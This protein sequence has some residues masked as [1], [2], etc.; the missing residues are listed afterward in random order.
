MFENVE[1]EVQY[2]PRGTLRLKG[3]V[4][5]AKMWG[6]ALK[7]AMLA[8]FEVEPNCR[9]EKH[10]HESEQITY[11]LEGKLFFEVPKGTICVKKG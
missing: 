2:F 8:Y 11:I 7:K 3:D 5:S 6:V 1:N 9:F 10:G 4:P